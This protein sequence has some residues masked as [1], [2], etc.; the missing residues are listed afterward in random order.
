M[1]NIKNRLFLLAFV[2]LSFLSVP[3]R[4]EF[5]RS[6]GSGNMKINKEIKTKRLVKIRRGERGTFID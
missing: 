5:G 1:I 6:L 3:A 2:S 4:A